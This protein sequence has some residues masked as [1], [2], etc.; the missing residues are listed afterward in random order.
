MSDYDTILFTVED[1]LAT[2]TLNRPD[3]LNALSAGMLG[4]LLSA[5]RKVAKPSSDV[6]C[7]MI[8]GA[9]RAFCSGADLGVDAFGDADRDLGEALI[10]SY[11][12]VLLEISALNI[13]VISVVNGVAAGAGMSIALSGDIVIAAKSAYFLQAFVNI[14]LVPDA[15]S[16]YL[17]PRLVGA[18]RARALMMLGERLPAETAQAWGL[19]FEA[20]DD[21]M[22]TERG[23]ELANSLANGPTKA[24]GAIRQLA[25][26]SLNN[27]Y[28]DQLHQESQ[29][30]RAAGRSEDCV[31]GVMAFIQKRP[32]VF[33][34][35]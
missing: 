24:L 13:P 7:L 30:Q 4:D 10:Q 19:I 2:I 17:L 6:R 26:Q 21:D 33:K 3:S 5:I 22:L 11:H 35:K 1:G 23:T 29:M 8:T 9:G 12:P 28:A 31:E 32:A 14:G 25:A 18:A 20:V 16:T 27:N 15:G 34:G